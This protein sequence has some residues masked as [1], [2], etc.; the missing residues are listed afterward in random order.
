[1]AVLLPVNLGSRPDAGYAQ[2]LDRQI[3]FGWISYK[4]SRIRAK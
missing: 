3:T 1:M 4:V 2:W